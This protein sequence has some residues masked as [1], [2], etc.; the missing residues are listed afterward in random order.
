MNPYRSKYQTT[1]QR[2]RHRRM[3]ARTL[4]GPGFVLL[5]VL[6]IVGIMNLVGWIESLESRDKYR[7]C[8]SLNVDGAITDS[9]IEDLKRR[10]ATRARYHLED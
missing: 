9:D 7:H 3:R 2:I 1:S 10:C 5:G 6:I 8:I 4:E